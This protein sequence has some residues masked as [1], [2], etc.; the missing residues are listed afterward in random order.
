[1]RATGGLDSTVEEWNPE[2]RTGTGFKFQGLKAEEFLTAIQRALGVFAHDK[3]GWQTLM[4]N[5]MAQDHSWA[6]P[7]A[8]YLEVYEEVARARN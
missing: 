7:A 4:R 2:T 5:G 6:R 8:E 3:E 1:V